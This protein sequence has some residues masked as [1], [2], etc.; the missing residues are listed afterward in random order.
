M[1]QLVTLRVT[2]R[3][4]RT[5]RIWVPVLPVVLVLSPLVVLVVLAV[6]VACLMY[7]VS[8]LRALGGGWRFVCALPGARCYLDDGRMAVLAT[9]R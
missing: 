5:I 4:R 9:I 2:R 3:D 1:P 7:D 6:V 8:V